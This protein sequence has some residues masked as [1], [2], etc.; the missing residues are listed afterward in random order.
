MWT[1]V[2]NSWVQTSRYLPKSTSYRPSTSMSIRSSWMKFLGKVL[3]VHSDIGLS[4]GILVRSCHRRSARYR[5]RSWEIGNLGQ[6]TLE[7]R[8]GTWDDSYVRSHSLW[9]NYWAGFW[10]NPRWDFYLTRKEPTV[11]SRWGRANVVEGRE[12]KDYVD[13]E[14]TS[15]RVFHSFHK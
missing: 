7:S 15:V 6:R 12:V 8:T 4:R 1:L 9:A 5:D 10:G 14:S 3:G 2:L 11:L 13:E